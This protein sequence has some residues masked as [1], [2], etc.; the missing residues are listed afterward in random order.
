MYEKEDEY[1]GEYQ[2]DDEFSDSSNQDEDKMDKKSFDLKWK[3]DINND[4]DNPFIDSL[5][6]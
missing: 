6:D 2:H 5:P 3:K 4:K 1:R